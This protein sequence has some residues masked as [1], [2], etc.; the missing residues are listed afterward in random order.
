MALLKAS[1]RRFDRGLLCFNRLQ[2]GLD[3][4]A[5]EENLL[6]IFLSL[7]LLREAMSVVMGENYNYK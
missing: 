2:E 4:T 6:K 3:W 7:Y 1:N 5:L